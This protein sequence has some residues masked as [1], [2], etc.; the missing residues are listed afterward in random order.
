[1]WK[2]FWG[3][4]CFKWLNYGD[5]LSCVPPQA[6][7]EER[8]SERQ[9]GEPELASHSPFLTPTISVGSSIAEGTAEGEQPWGC[10]G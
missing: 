8:S 6:V 4:K 2:V 9:L 3:V 10:R 7:L 5:E 1:M